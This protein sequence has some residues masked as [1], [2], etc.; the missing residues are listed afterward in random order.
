MSDYVIVPAD[1]IILG[2]ISVFTLHMSSISTVRLLLLLLVV[3]V[4]LVLVS[5]LALV[6]GPAYR[7]WYSNSLRAGRSGDRIPVCAKF[8]ASF[9]TGTGAHPGPCTIG[10][11]T[12]SRG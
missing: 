1:C 4:V 6:C 3:V 9:Q 8:S 7:S 10:T 11:E 5:V 12:L 2:I